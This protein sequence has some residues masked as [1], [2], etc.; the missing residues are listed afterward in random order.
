MMSIIVEL[1][2]GVQQRM[3]QLSANLYQAA[4]Q[5]ERATEMLISSGN[6]IKSLEN[7]LATSKAELMDVQEH[8]AGFERD[9][10]AYKNL[11]QQEATACAR[12]EILLFVSL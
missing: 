7:S 12:Q 3:R 5:L 10:E 9:V 8:T 2:T 4:E 1:R 11:Y 6:Q